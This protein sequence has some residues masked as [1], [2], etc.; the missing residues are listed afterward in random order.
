MHA[1]IMQ[2][3]SFSFKVIFKLVEIRIPKIN[4]LKNL[5]ELEINLMPSSY[6]LIFLLS[7]SSCPY[8]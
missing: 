2:I 7:F 5:T 1:I 6:F 8:K 3:R 4:R